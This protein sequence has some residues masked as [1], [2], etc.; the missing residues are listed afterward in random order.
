M[1]NELF[2]KRKN[3]RIHDK[4]PDCHRSKQ[5][6]HWNGLL[7]DLVGVGVL[8]FIPAIFGMTDM[9]FVIGQTQWMSLMGHIVFAVIIAL[10]FKARYDCGRQTGDQPY[11]SVTIAYI[12]QD[13]WIFHRLARGFPYYQREDLTNMVV[14]V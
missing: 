13:Q 9:I 1:G 5:F 8:I 12:P 4:C 10:V 6:F 2:W 7:R 3:S 11:T 14:R